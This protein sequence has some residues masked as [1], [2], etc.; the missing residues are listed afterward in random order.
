MIGGIYEETINI[1][2]SG[3]PF[4]SDIPGLG[5]LFTN[6]FNKKELTE[7]LVFLTTTIVPKD[8]IGIESTD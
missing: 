1:I 4:F 5:R 7:L 8:I 3:V 6:T 2:K